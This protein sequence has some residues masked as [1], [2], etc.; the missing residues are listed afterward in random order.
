MTMRRKIHS[1]LGPSIGS[2]Y[3]ST[4]RENTE[5]PPSSTTGSLH[6]TTTM[7]G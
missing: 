6:G 5:A 1:A 7:V 3:S 2:Q 4:Y